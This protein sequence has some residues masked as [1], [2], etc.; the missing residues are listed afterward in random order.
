M[1]DGAEAARARRIGRE[2][3]LSAR[4]GIDDA[5]R[6]LGRTLADRYRI[7]RFLGSGGFADV[8]AATVVGSRQQVAVKVLHPDVAKSE[9]GAVRFRQEAQFISLIAHPNI[10][11]VQ[12]Y[13]TLED[14]TPYMVM[15][16]LEGESVGAVLERQVI[17]PMIA[18][19]IAME[20]CEGLAAAHQRGVIHRDVKPDNLFLERSRTES[21]FRVKIL[22]LGVAKMVGSAV[23]ANA[24]TQRG[25]LCGTPDY[26][27]PEQIAG[28]AIGPG[29]DVY[30]LSCVLWAM[31]LGAPPFK[32]VPLFEILG[33]HATATPQWPDDLARTLGVPSSTR[34][35]LLHGLAKDPADR[36]GSMLE[37]QGEIASLVRSMRQ[38][39]RMPPPKV[40]VTD[41][42]E[43]QAPARDERR[44]AGFAGNASPKPGGPE[45]LPELSVVPPEELLA[46][47]ARHRGSARPP[48]TV[49]GLRPPGSSATA[50]QPAGTPR[51][52]RRVS[53]EACRGTD[54]EVGVVVPDVYWVGLRRDT[55]LECNPYL[56]VFTG[57]G[58]EVS[59]LVGPGPEADLD[60][61]LEKVASVIGSP[62]RLDYVF[63]HHPVPDVAGSVAPLVRA[64]P[65]AKVLCS[66]DT[67][68]LLRY[69][70]VDPN[71]AAVVEERSS[72]EVGTGHRVEFV[73]SPF[74]PTGGAVMLHDPEAR[75]LFSGGLFGGIRQRD[76]VA[77]EA[78]WEGIRVLHQ[79][80]MP[81]SL[82]LRR[83]V[84]HVRRLVPAPLVIAPQH[85]AALLGEHV[86]WV[87]EQIERLRTGLDLLTEEP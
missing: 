72:I 5:A 37:L 71:S 19:R 1:D 78:S 57:R 81:S 86:L 74:C 7:D 18:F 9:D 3:T 63:L 73:P 67:W 49:S 4:P 2:P 16:L 31:L 56:R 29:A 15:E 64:C 12:D 36:P 65:A 39:A 38:V 10:V 11:S 77:T 46:S 40:T 17:D 23:T 60:V 84:Q 6:W 43:P 42:S 51:M 70:G 30:A 8:F 24:L 62:K 50:P 69:Y 55:T 80:Y 25:M 79:M 48:T 53:L 61:V 27:A 13:G 66:K 87:L 45:T 28:T 44:T 54:A 58:R 85:G 76:L 52:V 68:R 21:Q 82:A 14:G 47:D 32:D 20:T 26:M 83:A 41:R 33:Q 75:V 59:I 22:D 35:V 34:E